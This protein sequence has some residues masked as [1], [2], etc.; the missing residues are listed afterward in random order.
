[1]MR[2]IILLFGLLALN[3]N[4]FGQR[5]YWQRYFGG[6][7]FDIGTEVLINKDWTLTIGGTTYSKDNIGKDQH[8]DAS[9]ILVFKFATQGKMFWQRNFGGSGYE[10]LSSMVPTKDGGYVFV[11]TTDSGDGDTGQGFGL[12]DIWIVKLNGNG[13]IVWTRRFGGRGNDQGYAILALDDGGFMVGGAS[14][15]Q[16]GTNVKLIHHGGI[17][18][19]LARLDAQGNIVWQKLWG[20]RR[21]EWV[22]D[23]VKVKEGEY[24]VVHAS[25]SVGGDRL[26]G[27]GEKDAWVMSIDAYGNEKWQKNYGGK[28]NDEIHDA[29]ADGKG[30]VYMTGSSFSSTV[31]LKAHK[32]QGDYWVIKLDHSGKVLWSKN[33]GGAKAEGANKIIPT[34]DGNI[35]IG[36]MTKSKDGDVE[37]LQGF[38]DGWIL[39]LDPNGRKLW[40]RSLGFAAKDIVSSLVETPVGGYLSVGYSELPFNNVGEPVNLSAYS[41]G[42]DVWLCNFGDPQDEE[43][44]P[45]FTPTL[46]SG[47]VK[48][49]SSRK[50]IQAD[51]TITNNWTLDSLASTASKRGSGE[52]LM[53]MPSEGLI[54]IGVLAKGYMLYGEDILMDTLGVKMSL[55]K[56]IELDPIALGKSLVLGNIYFNIGKWDLLPASYA[57]LERLRKFL[58]LNPKVII[59]IGGHTDN[60]GNAQDKIQ[61]SLYRAEAVQRYLI[62]KGIPEKKTTGQRLWK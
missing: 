22:R 58:L 36:G 61:L 39:K 41:G 60:T 44:Q 33:F 25:S 42:M 21:D 19:W 49:K 10:E 9:D 13:N 20:G 46:L 28:K 56:N 57:E 51:I 55:V 2:T 50:A 34:K 45:F 27:Y 16:N 53:E 29:W 7:G 6:S 54:S 47:T 4:L 62:A 11:G 59:E 14:G 5:A 31:H 23:I 38:Y 40:S 15:S 12:M 35:L 52:F 48:D 17:D 24:W 8:G 30:A 43:V 32:G 1:M 18:S 26:G 3:Q 37:L